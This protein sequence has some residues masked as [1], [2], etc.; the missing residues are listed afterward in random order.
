MMRHSLSALVAAVALACGSFAVAQT[1]GNSSS[2]SSGSPATPPT[3]PTE[4]SAPA[5]GVPG[6]T[7]GGSM[8]GG[9]SDSSTKGDSSSMKG[10]DTAAEARQACKNLSSAAERKQCMDKAQKS[11]EGASGKSTESSGSPSTTGK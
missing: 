1:S 11:S 9:S 8:Q 4:R 7:A 10:H 6:G 2:G 5:T 3:H